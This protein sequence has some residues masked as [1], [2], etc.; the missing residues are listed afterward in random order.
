MAAPSI[1]ITNPTAGS[2]VNRSFTANGTY[3]SAT[4]PTITLLLKDS[5][6]V[7]VATGGPVAAMG[8]QWAGP[9]T[10]PEA[11]TG[12][13]VYV[14]INGTTANDSVGNITVQ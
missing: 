6:G 14:A 2:T 3:T 12:A 10:A 1:A 5:A 11:Y 7:T 4:I 9:I 8:G 13:T